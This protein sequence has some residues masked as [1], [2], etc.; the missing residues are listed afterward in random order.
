MSIVDNDNFI[1]NRS[2]VNYSCT[3][4]R[5]K[6]EMLS[7]DRGAV[8]AFYQSSAPTYWTRVTTGYNFNA[9]I[10]TYNAQLTGSLVGGSTAMTTI[11]DKRVVPIATHSHTF[12]VRNHG[13]ANYN[14]DNH[15]H[16]VTDPKHSHDS[17]PGAPH[18]HMFRNGGGKDPDHTGTEMTYTTEA[19]ISGKINLLMPGG[20]RSSGSSRGSVGSS[21]T[22]VTMSNSGATSGSTNSVSTG[23]T[24]NNS[25]DNG[26][27]N[28][29]VKYVDVILCRKD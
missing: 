10:R 18:I 7:M 6:D 23:I 19:P 22:G 15:N 27:T 28:F 29:K 3:A 11:L 9:T 25:A 16:G 12:S 13:H 24:V 21:K 2:S 14:S 26:T 20:T 1:I 5:I 17:A 8:M 4:K